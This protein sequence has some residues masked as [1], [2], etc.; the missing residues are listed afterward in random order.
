LLTLL[1][2]QPLVH[3]RSGAAE[4]CKPSAA[5]RNR[6]EANEEYL[7][8]PHTKVSKMKPPTCDFSAAGYFRAAE[9]KDEAVSN[10][11]SRPQPDLRVY[12]LVQ[13][14]P[15]CALCPLRYFPLANATAN[16]TARNNLV[17]GRNHV[18]ET[19]DNRHNNEAKQK[20]AS[21]GK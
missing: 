17:D 6:E 14:A 3:D 8:N 11:Q 4:A 18:T 13:T 1:G 20:C 12:R 16:P 7:R 15:L 5:L 9:Q 19:F 10:P 2:A 21:D